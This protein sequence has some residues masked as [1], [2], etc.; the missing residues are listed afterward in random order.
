MA[1]ATPCVED[2][3]TVRERDVLV[4]LSAGKSNREIGSALLVSRTTVDTHLLSIFRKLGVR[5]RTEAVALALRGRRPAEG[6]H[7][8]A[9]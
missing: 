9:S 6:T 8:A 4:Q 3:L 1:D 7:S 5:N 2:L